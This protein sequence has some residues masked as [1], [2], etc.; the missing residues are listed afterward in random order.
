MSYQWPPDLKCHS[1]IKLRLGELVRGYYYQ[2]TN[3]CGV[4]DC[5]NSRCR[6]NPEFQEV[7]SN[8]CAFE[9][10]KNLAR[11]GFRK[12]K[13]VY[14]FC[15]HLHYPVDTLHLDVLDF[16]VLDD[17]KEKNRSL[18]TCIKSGFCYESLMY[19]FLKEYNCPANEEDSGIDI[20]SLMKSYKLLSK[21]EEIKSCMSTTLRAL[22]QHMEG[23]QSSQGG[24]YTKSIQLR[25][26]FIL[27]LWPEIGDPDHTPVLTTL[28]RALCLLGKNMRHTLISW[29]SKLDYELFYYLVAHVVQNFLTL[30]LSSSSYIEKIVFHATVVLGMLY[31]ASRL[32]GGEGKIEYKEFYNDAVN[33]V[34]DIKQDYRRWY[35]SKINGRTGED[36]DSFSFTQFSFIL[37]PAA[38]S[39]VLSCNAMTQQGEVQS[40]VVANMLLGGMAA[41]MITHDD[42]ICVLRI[43]RSDLI[44][45][46]LQQVTLKLDDLKKP[47][48]IQFLGEDGIDEGGVKK[49]FFQ[50]L[51]KEL[52]DPLYGMFKYDEQSHFHWFNQNSFENTQEFRLI[53]IMFGLA[54]YNSVILDIRFPMAIYKKMLGMPV[55]LKDL[56][57]LDAELYKGLCDL[58]EFEDLDAIEEM[59]QRNFTVESDAYGAQIQVALKPDGENIPLTKDNRDE[60]VQLYTS[61]ILEDSIKKQFDAF[62]SGFQEVCGCDIF[63]MFGPEELELLI[64]G[65]P[66][67]DFHGLEK[68]CRY[69]GYTKT[70]ETIKSFWE[71]VHTMTEDERKRLLKFC[72]GSDRVPI[73]GLG[74]MLFVVARNGDDSDMLP[75]AHTCFNH[76]MLP[77]YSSKEKLREKLLLAMNNCTGFGLM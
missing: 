32:V 30:N 11:D 34:V 18:I 74:S 48:R 46:S 51:T 41:P 2:L 10:A 13:P 3:G 66:D 17:A 40:A 8:A 5:K 25:P 9:E 33:S 42:L 68:E 60:Y 22:A 54:I 36:W 43:D 37:D 24:A 47:L 77:E 14:Y 15:K 27:F 57:Q 20:E 76:L 67:L 61:Y 16:D 45:S 28:F 69:D 53:G 73:K 39:M 35:D 72:T 58:L 64:C 12:P 1:D 49:E 75:T 29:L 26:I 52:F 7:D 55:G 31:E 71:I 38:K 70:S 19:S 21:D 44:Q 6:S 62:N 65:S 4:G 50:L 56:K 23:T 63:K 59:Y